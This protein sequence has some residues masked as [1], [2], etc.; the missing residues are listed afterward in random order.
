MVK[1]K[2]P[3]NIQ[4]SYDDLGNPV[5]TQQYKADSYGS[6]APGERAQ[7]DQMEAG[8][9]DEQESTDLGKEAREGEQTNGN[10]QDN[11]TKTNESSGK[12]GGKIPMSRAAV[13]KLLLRRGGPAGAIIAVLVVI[14]GIFGGPSTLFLNLKENLTLNFDQQNTLSERRSQKMLAKRLT[15]EGTKGVCGKV[16]LA[17]RYTK[18][19]N[20]Q[21]LDL[22]KANIKAVTKDG[23]IISKQRLLNGE[24]PAYY[25]FGETKDSDGIK[26][27][28]ATGDATKQKLVPAS[29]FSKEL[30][31]NPAFR[32][33]FRRAYNPRWVNWVDEVA[34][35]FLTKKLG[36]SK[37]INKAISEAADSKAMQDAIVE[38]ADGKA[39][40]LGDDKAETIRAAVDAESKAFTKASLRSV[41]AKSNEITM[42]ATVICMGVKA[43]GVYTTVLRNY[44]LVQMAA[45]VLPAVF[46]ATDAIKSGNGTPKMAENL[47]NFL[48]SKDSNGKTAM[49]SGAMLYGLLG[50]RAAAK[51]SKTLKKYIPGYTGNSFLDATTWFGNQPAIKTGCSAVASGEVDLAAN[52]IRALALSNTAG[53]IGLI[54]AGG[55]Y[56]AAKSGALEATLGPIIS[57]AISAINSIIDWNFILGL[58][59]GDF[60]SSAVGEEK[61]DMIAIT[62]GTAAANAANNA[63]GLP[64]TPEQKVTYDNEVT[65][66]TKLAWAEED[67][68]NYSPLDA[69]NPNTFM[70]SMLTK[71][72]GTYG[73]TPTLPTL[74]FGSVS[75][76]GKL[77][78]ML[79]PTAHASDK[80]SDW[81]NQ[82]PE[83]ADYSIAQSNVATDPLCIPQYAVPAEYVEV[84]NEDVLD[85]L[86][87]RGQIDAEGEVKASSNLEGNTALCNTGNTYA[88][89][90]CSFVGEKEEKKLKAYSVLYNFDKRIADQMDK[91]PPSPN[92]ST[93]SGDT[94]GTTEDTGPCGEGTINMGIYAN[95]HDDGK[96]TSIRL[97]AVTNLSAPAYKVTSHYKDI[98]AENPEEQSQAEGKALVNARAS[99]SVYAMVEA[100][101]KDD[102]I[103]KLGGYFA[104]RSYEHQADLR[105]RLGDQAAKAGY[106]NHEMGLAIDFSLPGTNH[107]ISRNASKEMQWLRANAGKF[108]FKETV[109]KE[110]WHWAYR[111]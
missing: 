2:D 29:A 51:N 37:S 35:N 44:R 71:F 60:I 1:L 68:L 82:C 102:V 17:C 48:T 15:G 24:R 27:I 3:T 97:C 73:A 33:A 62:Y 40:E 67:R 10:W 109:A 79:S 85:Y 111:P 25:Y 42:S 99:T 78:S 93:S 28:I 83:D 61:G 95:A 84:D 105:A 9:R 45:I 14:A 81:T 70:G 86:Y 72:L 107:H 64:L 34:I 77:P 46:V 98:K 20:K 30:R 19:S 96:K 21:L 13:A 89:D 106:S 75:L 57:G 11:Y 53:W 36:V 4:G 59:T 16:S 76:I 47:G 18:P 54:L 69:S 23:S 50:D 66:P 12:R 94:G 108:N 88:L 49:E 31:T 101:K 22:E 110:D 6:M 56:V 43:P 38:I 87:D 65:N 52:G 91:A 74:V 5:D 104:F 55:L 7:L 8:I 100:A 63:G 103:L 41:A 92:G 26:K 39:D 32:S 58:L 90:E 80:E